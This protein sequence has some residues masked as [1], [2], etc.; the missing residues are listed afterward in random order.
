MKKWAESEFKIDP[1]LNLI[2]SLYKKLINEGLDFS[3]NTVS[4]PKPRINNDPNVVSTQQEE[5]DI[6]KGINKIPATNKIF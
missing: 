2:P 4:S 6:A 1:Q 3:D 5:D